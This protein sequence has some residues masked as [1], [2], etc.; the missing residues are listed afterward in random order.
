[1]LNILENPNL[2]N[3]SFPSLTHIGADSE[4]YRY[5][6]I[7]D[8]P[9]LTTLNGFP[10]LEYLRDTFSLRDNPSL[11]DCDAIC[12]ML[13]RGIEPWRFK[14]SGNDFPCNS[15][16]DI[17][18]HICDT[19]T[20]IFTPEK[21]AAAFILA[22]PN[23]TTSDFQLSIPKMQLPAEMHI[24]DPTGKRIRRE[25]VTSL[26]QHFQIAGLPPGIYYIH[27]PGLNA[28]GKLIKTP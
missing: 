1:A 3:F 22:Y 23:P 10:N 7:R 17:E 6:S 13:D 27:F 9:A 20:T 25:R 16:A 5:I 4:K 21:E 26:R 8:N 18:E 19:L 24:Y 15:I 2:E 12:R 14:M 11:S 28:F